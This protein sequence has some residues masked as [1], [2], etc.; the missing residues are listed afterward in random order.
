MQKTAKE[1]NDLERYFVERV[2]AGD[3]DG[4]VALYEPT[5]VLISDDGLR[6][7]G[8]DQIRAFFV[9]YLQNGRQL[10]PSIQEPALSAGGLALTSSRHSNGALS[11]E[12]ARRQADGNWLWVIDKFA[13]QGGA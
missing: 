9:E 8:A 13:I 10:E 12:I 4:L 2:N 3:V 11:V 1:P 6:V 5:A 7:T